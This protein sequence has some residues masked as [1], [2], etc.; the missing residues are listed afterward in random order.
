[1]FD[2]TSWLMTIILGKGRRGGE[3]EGFRVITIRLKTYVHAWQPCH[4]L[5]LVVYT[6]TNAYTCTT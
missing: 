2:Y 3:V 1:M 5:L 6:Q 4:V